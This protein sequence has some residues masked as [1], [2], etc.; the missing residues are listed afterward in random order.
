MAAKNDV[1]KKLWY[2]SF[3]HANQSTI[4]NVFSQLRSRN[5]DSAETVAKGLLSIDLR[6]NS[7]TVKDLKGN[8]MYNKDLYDSNEAVEPYLST[9]VAGLTGVE[10]FGYRDKDRWRQVEKVVERHKKTRIATVYKVSYFPAD[11]NHVKEVTGCR[12][13]IVDLIKRVLAGEATLH[14]NFLSLLGKPDD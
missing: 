4:E 7:E 3:L 13:T 9:Q 6:N 11:C 5:R 10:V 12:T 1:S 2:V 14:E 8:K